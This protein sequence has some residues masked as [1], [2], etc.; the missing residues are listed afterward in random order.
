MLEKVTELLSP[1][2]EVVGAVE[3]GALLVAAA[4]VLRPDVIVLDFSMPV[5]DGL[6]ALRELKRRG[7]TAR[8]IFLTINRSLEI[9]DECLSSGAAAYIDKSR[10]TSG[11]IPAIDGALTDCK[12]L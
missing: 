9:A 8:I 12:F 7:S 4:E 1:Q 2:F 3:N 5:M 10:M 11:L 6:S